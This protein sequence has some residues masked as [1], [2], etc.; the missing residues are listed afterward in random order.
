[1]DI[2]ETVEILVDYILKKSTAEQLVNKGPQ[3]D[4]Q[5]DIQPVAQTV[6]QPD[7]EP[8]RQQDM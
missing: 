6:I 7:A 8:D 5:Q 4:R 3:I 2:L 1:M